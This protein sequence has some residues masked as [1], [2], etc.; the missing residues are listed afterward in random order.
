MMEPCPTMTQR[1]DLLGG[2][3]A[4]RTSSP[5]S[6]S[7]SKRPMPGQGGFSGARPVLEPHRRVARARDVGGVAGAHPEAPAI[8][9]HRPRAGR[10]SASA[11]AM[12]ASKTSSKST[13]SSRDPGKARS[14]CRGCCREHRGD[15]SAARQ[16]RA[17]SE[18][19]FKASNPLLGTKAACAASD[20]PGHSLPTSK[21]RPHE[22][23]EAPSGSREQ[24]Q[25]HRAR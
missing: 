23:E 7:T 1:R 9:A 18:A 25:R 12:S 4:P 17:V 16:A 10:S 11:A 3:S 13:S 8:Q 20:V 14:S 2:I 5:S 6:M 21:A 15:D 22:R 19:C 24:D